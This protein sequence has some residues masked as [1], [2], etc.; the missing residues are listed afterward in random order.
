MF[1]V[2][3]GGEPCV[4]LVG[5]PKENPCAIL[6]GSRTHTAKWKRNPLNLVPILRPAT[7]WS[8][9][10]A[11][12]SIQEFGQE[13]TSILLDTQNGLRSNPNG[14]R[15]FKTNGTGTSIKLKPME[16]RFNWKQKRKADLLFWTTSHPHSSHV[17]KPK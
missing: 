14:F 12:P 16:P 15:V 11:N 1:W 9:R 10:M 4:G 7:Q 6:G 5:S 13:A 3:G 8:A 17:K 2:L